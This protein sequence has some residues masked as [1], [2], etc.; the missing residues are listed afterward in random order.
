MDYKERMKKEY[1]EL[2]D[3]YNKLHNMLV[4]FAAGNLEFEPTCPISLLREQELAMK[5]Y[6]DILEV[7]AQ[8]EKV[9]LEG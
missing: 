2:K 7:R 3:R 6:L 5:T 4:K 1:A 8:I 9:D